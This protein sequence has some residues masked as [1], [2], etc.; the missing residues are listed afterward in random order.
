M[1]A[2]DAA[3]F[4]LCAGA[5]FVS[6]SALVRHADRIA[7]ATGFGRSWA[8]FLLL[9]TVTSLPEAATGITASALGH[10][11][12]AVGDVL[13]ST[14]FNLVI[15]A[16]LD[17]ASGPASLWARLRAGHARPVVNSAILLA[18]VGG[19]IALGERL[20]AIGP[21][22][23]VAFLL[24]VAY[25]LVA[26]GMR[27]PGSVREGA[28]GPVGRH[29]LLF[30]IHA[31][32]V[33][34]AGI[35]LPRAAVAI[36]DDTGL[37]RTFVG[38]LFVA[39]TTSLPEVA[40]TLSAIRIGA[41]DLAVADLVGSNLFDLFLLGVDD[42]VYRPGPI[43]QAV[44]PVHLVTAVG[45]VGAHLTLLL[46]LRMRPVGKAL[47]SVP[48]WGIVAIALLVAALLGADAALR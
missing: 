8:G 38:T 7:S 10:A 35:L 47:L 43:L 12:I 42:L 41:W 23:P 18:A 25:P 1:A 5:V 21:V 17:L 20:P 15:L 3:L 29:A 34:A 44:E 2:A 19:A 16:L 9:A 11:N 33:V 39:A 24:L 13:G 14:L 32:V 48:S 28:A 37:G 22:G 45:S 26:R 27:P 36:A 4:A 40:V 46:G 30:A 6:G 31:A